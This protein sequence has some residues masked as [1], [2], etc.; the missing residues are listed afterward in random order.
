[1]SGRLQGKVV[2]V[3]GASRGLGY[4]VCEAFLAEG[5]R[6]G[7]LARESAEL[8]AAAAAL[9]ESAFA[10]PADVSDPSAVRRAFATVQ[11]RGQGLHVLVNNAA[12]GCPQP[13]AEADDA[14]LQREVGVNLLGP[15]Y[16]MREAARLMRGGGGDVVNVSSESVRAPY[17]YLSVYAATK[18]GL[19][20]LSEGLRAELRADGI[21]VSV[22]RSGR[23]AESGFNRDWSTQVR[24]RHR[25]QAQ[26]Q[27]FHAASGEPISPVVA[28]S[29]IVELV[30]LP[31]AA[32]GSL[33]ELR[34]A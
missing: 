27:G 15:I 32:H 19:E 22:L 11:A 3:T 10:L 18:S 30:C 25:E 1:M 8:R 4:R 20:T 6:V 33:I 21:R 26:L 7:L 13:I 5:A 17:P 14:L 31:R 24:E 2:V 23:L 34:P 9:G 28:A 12:V 16:C 29:A